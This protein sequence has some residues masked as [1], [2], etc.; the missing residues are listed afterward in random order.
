[1]QAEIIFRYPLK[2]TKKLELNN[3]A[4]TICFPTGIKVCYNQEDPF[5][6][7][8]YMAPIT[9]QLGE[10]YYMMT[11]H[12]YV[13]KNNTDYI[14][15]YFMHPLKHHLMKFADP[16]LDNGNIDNKVF[17]EIEKNLEFCQDLGFREFVY[18]PHCLSIISK[19][20]YINQMSKCLDSIFKILSENNEG[21]INEM[22]MYLIESIPIP[23]Q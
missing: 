20:P 17:E 7:E 12:F 18:I 1:M 21:L 15:E 8:N 5:I 4:A 22:I 16:Y 19:Y 2:D 10:R 23:I 9:N 3:L 14:K 6:N 11:Y 13:K